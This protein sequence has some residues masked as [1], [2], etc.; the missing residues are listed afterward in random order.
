MYCPTCD[1]WGRNGAVR[2]HVTFHSVRMKRTDAVPP[3]YIHTCTYEERRFGTCNCAARARAQTAERLH[4]RSRF[5]KG[6]A[7]D[8]AWVRNLQGEQNARFKVE[9]KLRLAQMPS[10]Q[11]I[12]FLRA[13]LGWTQGRAARELGISRR[14]II[15][16]ELGQHQRPRMRLSL[17]FR[18]RQLESDYAEQLAAYVRRGGGRLPTW[19]SRS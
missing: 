12:R 18:L 9:L 3:A 8:L 6:Q 11:R 5:P 15:R 16:H 19:S 13:V 1:I 10:G 14:S 2:G 17:E 7:D 4:G